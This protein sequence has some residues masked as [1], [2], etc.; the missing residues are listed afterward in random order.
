MVTAFF[1][2]VSKKAEYTV[3]S[4]EKITFSLSFFR[5]PI[6]SKKIRGYPAP[7]EIE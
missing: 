1:I 4:T 3:F 5:Y 2:I 7:Y 6:F